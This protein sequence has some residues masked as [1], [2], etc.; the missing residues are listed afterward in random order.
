[1]S[2][3]RKL[4]KWYEQYGRQELPWR[5][6]ITPYRV[7][8]SEIMLQQTQVKTVLPYFNN[9]IKNFPTVLELALASDDEV[10]HLWSGLGYYTRA[11]NLHKAAKIIHDDFH[12]EF[13]KTLAELESL[14]GIG[15]STA[16]AIYSISYDKPAAIMDGNVKRVLS[17]YFAI[18]GWPGT[19]ENL[20]SLWEKSE[21]LLPKSRGN[22]YTQAIMDLG[23]ML[24]T[25]SKPLC[26]QCPVAKSCLAFTN[27]LTDTI[28]ASK[29]KK[30]KPIKSTQM[31]IIQNSEQHVLLEKRPPFGIWGSLWCLPICD[32]DIDIQ[33]FCK[34]EFGFSVK[35]LKKLASFRHTF[36]H[37]HLDIHPVI[38]VSKLDQLALK[39]D[40]PRTWHDTEC[41]ENLG[42]AA[43]IATLL[44]TVKN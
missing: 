30:L 19:T 13:P 35:R 43:P 17:R 22:D 5:Q 36:S 25:R 27:N 15:R 26:E 24:C 37:Y 14:P 7:W 39:E 6:F 41:P 31:L 18:E 9:F 29:P 40:K 32:L 28:P 38:L 16:A 33:D 2:F 23:A 3:S 11:R 44:K 20:K 8:L 4:L 34:K 10:L 1:M 21:S 12:G 42:L